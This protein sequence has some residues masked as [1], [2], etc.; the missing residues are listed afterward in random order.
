MKV[1]WAGQHPDEGSIHAW[2]DGELDPSEAALLDEHVR[3][4][5]ECGA[6]VAEARGL[7]AG[8]SRV[9]GQL[10]V[11]PA[12]LIQPATTPTLDDSGSMWRL[13]RVTPARAS[14]AALLLVALGITLTRT[15]AAKD[16]D[17]APTIASAPAASDMTAM[18]EPKET[19]APVKDHLLDS[20]IS[21]KLADEQPARTVKPAPGG[22]IP[23][24]DMRVAAAAVPDTTAGMRV[25]AARSAIRAR[26]DSA[27]PPADKARVG[28]ETRSVATLDRMANAG[29]AAEA[30]GTRNEL[31]AKVAGVLV[32]PTTASQC[33]LVESNAPG[34]KWGSATLPIVLAFDSTGTTARVLTPGG[35]DTEAAERKGQQRSDHHRA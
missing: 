6:R 35:A 3:G 10:D 15:K 9:I 16:S 24:E 20:A 31:S 32:G 17:V 33:L 1:E 13:L 26:S 5:T 28:F 27:S 34:A 22:A 11:T 19:P 2:L 14:I 4:C 30:A 12:R 25:A 29:Q 7:M 8:A 18:A 21:R 23:S